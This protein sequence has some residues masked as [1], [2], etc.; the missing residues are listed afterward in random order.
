MSGLVFPASHK[1]EALS[2]CQDPAH[3]RKCTSR[4]IDSS[5]G[6]AGTERLGLCISVMQGLFVPV[7]RKL[8]HFAANGHA[9]VVL[10]TCRL[11]HI[12]HRQTGF[13][14]VPFSQSAYLQPWENSWIQNVALLRGCFG[15]NHGIPQ[16]DVWHFDEEHLS[17]LIHCNES[18]L[19]VC[20]FR[21]PP[22]S[23]PCT[24]KS[25]E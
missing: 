21:I 3:S 16:S 1:K 18:L 6:V 5:S 2:P 15:T 14:G 12:R 9:E 22:V 10:P 7:H 13:A 23:F 4:M 25:C 8:S 20:K 24:S 11:N 19:F 17:I